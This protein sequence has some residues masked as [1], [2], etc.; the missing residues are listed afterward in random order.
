[1]KLLADGPPV[2]EEH[3]PQGI[4][5]SSSAATD[6]R[7]RVSTMD[8]NAVVADPAQG[9]GGNGE[10]EH[11]PPGDREGDA[12]HEV[13]QQ[14]AILLQGRGPVSIPCQHNHTMRGNDLHREGH[15]LA[16]GSDRGWCG[17][18]FE[19]RFR[20]GWNHRHLGLFDLQLDH[21]RHGL[22]AT[23]PGDLDDPVEKQ[24][25]DDGKIIRVGDG[26]YPAGE[27]DGFDEAGDLLQVNILLRGGNVIHEDQVDGLAIRRAV[28]DAGL[29]PADGAEQFAILPLG[30]DMRNTHTHADAGVALLLAKLDF[31]DRV[32]PDDDV[33]VGIKDACEEFK[34]TVLARLGQLKEA[35]LL[36]GGE[37]VAHNQ[38]EPKRLPNQVLTVCVSTP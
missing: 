22:R 29:G 28:G 21:P 12:G 15:R 6:G 2:R 32:G 10:D 20:L 37:D 27:L 25:P 8:R 11:L 18:G 7:R 24:V 19:V 36:K 26:L 35:A 5:P 9:V 33:G 38:S 16:A 34:G 31:L 1:M 17:L 4:L 3:Q 30:P 13:L 14:G 23:L